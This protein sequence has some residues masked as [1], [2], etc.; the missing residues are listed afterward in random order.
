MVATLGLTS[1]SGRPLKNPKTVSY[2]VSSARLR[3]LL[4]RSILF[5]ATSSVSEDI[6]IRGPRAWLRPRDFL[7]FWKALLGL[8]IFEPRSFRLGGGERQ[9]W[10]KYYC[11]VDHF[12]EESAIWSVKTFDFSLGRNS[13]GLTQFGTS[14]YT[15]SNEAFD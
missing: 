4:V 5:P 12:A 13:F 9:A 8:T 1:N 11:R 10:Q 2:S 3:D 7:E 15:L 6:S 14:L